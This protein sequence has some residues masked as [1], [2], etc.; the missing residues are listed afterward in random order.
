MSGERIPALDELRESLREAARRDIEAAA[1]RRRR[2][3]RR[4]A[5][6]LLA[7]AL[8][9]A[10]AAAGAAELISAGDP[11]QDTRAQTSAYRPDG[12]P[13]Q[14]D[15]RAADPERKETWVVGVYTARNG[16]QC[17]LAGQLRGNEIGEIAGGVFHAY[18]AQTTGSCGRA[19]TR[20]LLRRDDRTVVFGLAK[21]G[22]RVTA[23]SDGKAAHAVAG[24]DGGFLFVYR[25]TLGPADVQIDYG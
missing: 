14:I 18:G 13:M 23:T 22:A 24:R 6:G 12:T 4:R 17:A 21:P 16:E 25:G 7:V 3:R 10:A 15:A 19:G 9:G 2:R 5:G 11:V 20:D 1:P 8:L